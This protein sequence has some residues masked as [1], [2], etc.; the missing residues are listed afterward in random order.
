MNETTKDIVINDV[1][2]EPISVTIKAK[3]VDDKGNPLAGATFEL[4]DKYGN[5]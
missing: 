3:K 2:N 1:V 5:S 4:F